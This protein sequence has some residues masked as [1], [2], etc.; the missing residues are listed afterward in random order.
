MLGFFRCS[1]NKIEKR[2]GDRW[3]RPKKT[4]DFNQLIIKLIL[5]LLTFISLAGTLIPLV[6]LSKVDKLEAAILGGAAVVLSVLFA[7][8]VWLETK[9]LGGKR[10]Y[11]LED[12]KGISSYMLHWI[13]HGGRVAI[14]SR[15]LSWA[16]H[17]KSSE[18]LFEKAKRKELI[19]CLPAHTEMSEKLQS[20]GATVYIVGED[21][22]AEP[23][24]RFTIAYY[25]RD[26]SKVAVGRTKGDKH[27]IEEFSSGEHP[28]Y[29]LAYDLVK[30]AQSISERKKAVI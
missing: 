26:G 2:G 28:A 12:A 19:L 20:A 27:V 15:D 7:A 9:G 29:F 6:D 13:G 3:P 11:N 21:L 14:W 16:S 18:C 17:E 25:K 23:N 22:L 10:V 30:L 1:K 5:I 24:S 4:A 8:L